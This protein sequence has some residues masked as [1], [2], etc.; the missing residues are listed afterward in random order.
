MAPPKRDD[1]KGKG[2]ASSSKLPVHKPSR[3]PPINY[4][5]FFYTS[6]LSNYKHYFSKR[7]IT[8]EQYVHEKTLFDMLIGYE[9]VSGG[10]ESLMIIKGEVQEEVV[11][12]FWSNIDNSNLDT[13]AFHTK[14]YSVQINLDPSTLSTLLGIARPT[15]RT[16]SFPPRDLDKAIILKV[17]DHEDTM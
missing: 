2:K 5:S 7:P 11:W 6:R 9:L 10:R 3:P 4:G 14:V 16:V 12:V 8:V 17:F 1:P 15:R 13:L